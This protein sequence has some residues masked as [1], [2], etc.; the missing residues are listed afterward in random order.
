[1]KLDG[2]ITVKEFRTLCGISTKRAY[3]IAK[4][5]NFPSIKVGKRFYVKKDEAL[6]WLSS[7]DTIR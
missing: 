2:Y 3:D 5:R 4:L 1:M 6:V 7:Q